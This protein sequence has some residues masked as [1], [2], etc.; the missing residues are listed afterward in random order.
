MRERLYKLSAVQRDRLIVELRAKGWT[1]RAIGQ[2]V[3][4]DHSGVRRS[5]E[6]I[7]RGGQ[8]RDR[9]E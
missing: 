7:E 9:R 3:G 6:R 2:R 1:L 5:L 8:G 4:M